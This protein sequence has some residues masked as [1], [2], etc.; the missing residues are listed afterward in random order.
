MKYKYIP[1]PQPHYKGEELTYEFTKDTVEVTYKDEGGKITDTFDFTDLEDG[2][3]EIYDENGDSAID[4]DLPIQPICYAEKN[5][6]ELLVA[7][8]KL[9]EKMRGKTEYPFTLDWQVLSDG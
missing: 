7:V 2:I 1:K 6:G 9:H 4:T 5:D 3:L 8:I